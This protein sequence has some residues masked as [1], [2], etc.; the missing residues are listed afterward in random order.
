MFYFA[1][2]NVWVT[3][4]MPDILSSQWKVSEPLKLELHVHV[5]H[6]VGVGKQT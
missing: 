3:M 1:F 4:S 5:R 6:H 2:I